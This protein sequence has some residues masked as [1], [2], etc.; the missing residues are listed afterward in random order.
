MRYRYTTKCPYFFI[1][2]II[3]IGLSACSIPQPTPE[4]GIWYCEEL[5]I[6]IDFSYL[7]ENLSPDCAKR[8]NADGTYQDV[9]CHIDYGSSITICSENQEEDFLIGR[10]SYKNDI[11]L[12]TTIED[13]TTYVFERIGG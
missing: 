4:E 1:M 6:E 5:M 7:N 11:F 9:L 12:V 2:M 3:C 10:F 13:K 8:Y